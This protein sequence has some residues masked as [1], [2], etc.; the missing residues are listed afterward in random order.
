MCAMRN[1]VNSLRRGGYFFGI[2][3]NSMEIRRRLKDPQLC[4]DGRI[5]ENRYY[6]LEMGTTERMGN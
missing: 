6:R 1:V 2:I 4:P 5:L 3:P